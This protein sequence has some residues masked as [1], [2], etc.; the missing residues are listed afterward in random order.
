MKIRIGIRFKVHY[1]S[2]FQFHDAA[3]KTDQLSD[4]VKIQ[5]FLKQIGNAVVTSCHIPQNL[6]S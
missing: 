4:T 5:K 6:H 2:V 3:Q 1:T